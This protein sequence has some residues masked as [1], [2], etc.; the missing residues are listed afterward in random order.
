M[1]AVARV[2]DR[3]ALH[4]QANAEER[5]F[6]LAGIADRFDHAGNAAFAESARNQNS[7]HVAEPPRGRVL[8]IDFFRFNPFE[9]GAKFVRHTPVDQRF[10][11]A[12]VRVFQ[13]DVLPDYPDADFAFRIVDAL[14]KPSQG[15]RSRS[16]AS[17]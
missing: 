8:R 17:R 14:E 9:H 3:R 16:R 4:P 10:A 5:H 11:K 1:S 13:L 12:L 15:R 7:V 6:V 2:F